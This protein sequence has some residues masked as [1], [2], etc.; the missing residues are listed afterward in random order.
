MGGAPEPAGRR[1]SPRPG[2]RAGATRPAAEAA[3]EDAPAGDRPPPLQDAGDADLRPDTAYRLP[4]ALRAELQRPWG[5]VLDTEALGTRLDAGTVVLAVGDVVSLTLK[6]LGVTPRLFVCD[7]KTQRGEDPVYRRELGGWGETEH[8]VDNPAATVTR[9]AWDAV[10][11]SVRGTDPAPV[12]IVVD[13]EEDLL[14]I[15]CFLEAPR[16]AVVLYGAPGQGVVWIAIDD[17]FQ[18][19]VADFVR[20]MEPV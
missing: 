2:G 18:H 19:K 8:R 13:G 10:R 20:R 9:Q 5:P 1:E 16:G 12:R 15:P 11:D 17:A 14:G 4:E 7:Y 3:G 6:K